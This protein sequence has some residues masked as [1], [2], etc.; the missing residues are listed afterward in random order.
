MGKQL[1][2]FITCG[3]ESSA[4]FFVIYKGFSPLLDIL[5][6]SF[7]QFE[8]GI[9]TPKINH[10]KSVPITINVVSLNPAHAR[11]T[12]YNFT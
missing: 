2:N 11:C 3:C 4:L 6:A 9:K 8:S 5:K 7:Q 12:L 10:V 1:V